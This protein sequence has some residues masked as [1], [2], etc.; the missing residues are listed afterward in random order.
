MA[1]LLSLVEAGV[2]G[3]ILAWGG[4]GSDQL[5][6]SRISDPEIHHDVSLC[7]ARH[8]P[9]G[10]CAAAVQKIVAEI[11]LEIVFSPAWRGALLPTH[12]SRS[13]TMR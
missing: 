2:G 9:H 3:A 1:T 10:E 7:S 8:L 13:E 11:V 4:Q 12:L 6:W 5:V